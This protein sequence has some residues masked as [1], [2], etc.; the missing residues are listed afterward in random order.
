MPEEP[1][2]ELMDPVSGRH[3]LKGLSGG[4]AIYAYVGDEAPPA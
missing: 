2:L 1:L 3:E 4:R